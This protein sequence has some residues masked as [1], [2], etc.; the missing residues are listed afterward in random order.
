MKNGTL[1]SVKFSGSLM[2]GSINIKMLN[3]STSTRYNGSIMQNVRV[4][5]VV[6]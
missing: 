1:L 4:A 5:V 6:D 3:D 2:P